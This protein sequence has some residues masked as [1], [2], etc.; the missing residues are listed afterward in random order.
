MADAADLGSV[1]A[2]CAS[3]NLVSAIRYNSSL[4]NADYIDFRQFFFI[5]CFGT[6]I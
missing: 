1:V 2:R 3:S 5:P 4:T 6:F